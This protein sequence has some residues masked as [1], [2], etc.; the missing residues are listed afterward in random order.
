MPELPEVETI[1]RDLEKV[2]LRKVLVHIDIR[3]PFVLRTPPAQFSKILLKQAIVNIQRR[4]KALL[5]ELSNHHFLVVQLMMTGQL[6]V[7]PKPD[8][9]TRVVFRF[10][11]DSELL[12]NDQRRFGQ[13]RAVKDLKE[14]KHLSLL[15]PEPFD[16]TFNADYIFQYTRGGKR[17]IKNLLL[18]HTFVA[19]IGNIYACEI[20][21]RSHIHPKRLSGRL[22]HAQA[23]EIHQK[24]IEVLEEAIASRGSSMRNYRDGAGEKGE[25]IKRI[26]VYAREDQPCLRCKTPIRR[27]IQAGRSTFFC[28][29]CQKS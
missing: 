7:G 1:R 24:T 2:I 5:I 12:Y 15:G 20:L 4:G 22:T 18:D 17:P 9:H 19:G 23:K 29:Q 25:F 14:V 8:R 26:K 16:P 21:F 10:S 11:D 13:L 6:V 28:S 3:D 27:I